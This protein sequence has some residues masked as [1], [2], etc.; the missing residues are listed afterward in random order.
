MSQYLRA[1]GA[2]PNAETDR[3]VDAVRQLQLA[4][5]MQPSTFGVQS[6]VRMEDSEKA[7]VLSG[8][9]NMGLGVVKGQLQ[10]DLQK[11]G[12]SSKDNTANALRVLESLTNAAR[13]NEVELNVTFQQAAL[14]ELL[15]RQLASKKKPETVAV[16]GANKGATVKPRRRARPRRR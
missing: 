6:I 15:K 10:K 4:V 11:V 7:S 8:L 9:I 1:L 5:N 2:P 16:P 3:M 13:G 12:N 14:A